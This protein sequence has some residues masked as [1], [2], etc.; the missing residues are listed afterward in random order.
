ML[1]NT[2]DKLHL[3]THLENGR[4]FPRLVKLCLVKDRPP[5]AF[6][7]SLASS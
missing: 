7:E 4:L 3:E 1:G 6:L 2:G 5:P